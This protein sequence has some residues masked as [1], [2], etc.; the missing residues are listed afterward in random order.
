MCMGLINYEEEKAKLYIFLNLNKY[1]VFG[2]F[3]FV[4]H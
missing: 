1:I 2:N 3:K 4:T